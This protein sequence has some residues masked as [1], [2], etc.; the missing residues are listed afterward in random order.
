M[1]R[2]KK[3]PFAPWES[4]YADGMEK[5]YIRMGNTQM[6]SKMMMDLPASAFRV[7]CYMKLEAKGCKQFEFPYAKYRSYMSK[8]TFLDAKK[9]LIANGF[10]DEVQNN[11]NLRKANIYAFSDRWKSP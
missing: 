3:T 9:K 8:H 2:I 1:P 5:R 7:Y 6:C 10:I 11:R 4:T